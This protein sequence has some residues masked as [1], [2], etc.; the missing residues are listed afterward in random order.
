[1]PATYDVI[2][3][4]TL[5]SNQ[6]SVTFSSIPSTYTDIKMIVNGIYTFNDTAFQLRFNGDSGS[7]YS[8]T[9]IGGN[10]SSAFS[11]RNTNNIW[12]ECGWYQASGGTNA[13]SIID[14]LNYANTTTFKTL[15]NRKGITSTSL[16]ANVGMWRSTS[17][18]N[19]IAMS[20]GA[21]GSPNFATGTTFTLYGIKAA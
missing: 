20:F 13:T 10:G 16:D 11:A 2:E 21:Y 14:V 4:R 15:L 9:I 7:N 6:S 17:A 18:I 8:N 5:G 1:M 19:S 3:A 12:I